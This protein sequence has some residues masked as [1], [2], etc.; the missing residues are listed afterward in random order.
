MFPSLIIAFVVGSLFV[1][2]QRYTHVTPQEDNKTTNTPSVVPPTV[3]P[4]P[5]ANKIL[6]TDYHVYQTFNNCGPAALSMALAHYGIFESQQALGQEL[7]PWQN[8]QGDN[9]D[10]SVTLEELAEKSKDYGLIPYNRP[11]GNE[12]IIKQFIAHGIPIIARTWLKPDDD[13][14]H[15]RVIKGYNGNSLI[16][17]DSL[18]GK[19]R[20]YTFEEFD[21]LW[22]KYN[23]EYLV[24]IPK[25]KSEIAKAVLQEDFD[26]TEA[27]QK[28]AT[29]AR[30]QLQDDPQDIY[31]RFNL[32][33]ALHNIGDYRQSVEEFEKVEHQLPPRTLWYQVEP[34]KSYYELGLFPEVLEI[35]N[36][37]LTNHNRA[38]S[39]L[40]IL[41][42]NIFKSQGNLDLARREYEL[43]VRYNRNLD[44]ASQAL[45]ALNR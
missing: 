3:L 6:P 25:E 5:P 21:V 2:L 39:E 45:S 42:G 32:S 35:T 31:A 15:Y 11:N 44:T 28:A 27:W 13:I 43:A 26:E 18:Q 8:T 17:D 36:H 12:H 20:W 29:N 41:R 38:Y 24:L 1:A 7:R 16:Q 37:I 9:D 19:N 14:G 34:I 4:D 10:K 33:V 30:K 23:F 22:R 40:Y